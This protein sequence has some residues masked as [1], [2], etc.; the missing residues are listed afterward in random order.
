MQKMPC[1]FERDF[2]DQRNPLLLPKVTPGCAWVTAGEGV[3]TRKWDGTACAVYDAKRGK[4]PPPGAIPCGE[5]D[6]VTGHWPHWVAVDPRRAE[7]RWHAMT[8]Q[9]LRFH[10]D[11][12]TYE[13]CGPKIG[14][15]A[16]DLPTHEFYRHGAV[17]LEFVP[18][19]FEGLREYLGAHML[20]GIV[21]HHEDG[22][23][24]KIRRHDF[25]L[26]W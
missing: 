8:W 5:P 3:P 20:E 21:F 23:R 1:L 26:P 4:E 15:N 10:L 9:R 25:G 16:E 18:R 6:A 14:A 24:C 22:R 17:V 12:G 13:L 7:D 19:D 2:T 11:D